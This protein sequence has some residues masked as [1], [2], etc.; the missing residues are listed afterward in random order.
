MN[1]F[2][3]SSLVLD[4]FSAVEEQNIQNDTQRAVDALKDQVS[5]Q[6]NALRDWSGWDN[7]YAFMEDRNDE[8]VRSSLLLNSNFLNLQVNL[9]I[10]AD[11]S[12]QIV[13]SKAY[14]LN[15][16]KS[17]D[18]GTAVTAL[19]SD[20]KLTQ[21]NTPG[22]EMLPEGAIIV[23]S[24][25]ILPADRNGIIR[26]S[27]IWGRYL[28]QA[29]IDKL[30]KLTHLT[31]DVKKLSDEQLPDDFRDA[32]DSL[33]NAPSVVKP[34]DNDN[35]AGYS[36]IDDIHGN[37][38]LILRVSG[39]RTIFSQAQVTRR[40]LV[41]AIFAAGLAFGGGILLLLER[42]VL[43]R[44]ARLS[45]GLAKITSTGN[46]ASR[47]Q[48]DGSDEL[49]NLASDINGM[50]AALEHS[51]R[52]VR[53]A[54]DLLE[55]KVQDRTAQLREKIAVLQTLTEIDREV[56]GAT[57]SKN[58]LTL[59]CHR[60][61]ELL[62][63]PKGL[64]TLSQNG[65][66]KVA[67]RVGL[68]DAEAVND[69]VTKLLLTEKTE[70]NSAQETRAITNIA[71][72]AAAGGVMKVREDIKS[73]AIAP[74]ATESRDL[75]SLMVFDTKAR[76][77]KADELQVLHLLAVQAALALEEAQLLE[78]EQSRREELGSLY[79]LSRVL[80]DSPPVIDIVVER[81]A[82]HA[83]LTTHV[84]FAAV[85]L[86]DKKGECVLRAS[87]PV[88]KLDPQPARA[89]SSAQRN[90]FCQKIMRQDEP[91]VINRE[92]VPFCELVRQQLLPFPAHT[93]CI[94]PLRAGDRSIGFI[95]LGE[96]RHPEREP[97]SQEKLRL[98][99]SIADQAVS[100]LGR[101]ELFNQLEQS[102]METVLSLAGAV[103]AR[104]A[105]TA[106]HTES[107]V[108]MALAIAQELNFSEQELDDLR[109]GVMLHDVGKIGIP[110]SVLQKPSKLT[111]A[112]WHKM[113]QHPAIGARIMA[114]VPRFKSAALVVRHHHERF[115]GHGYPDG[116]NGEAI[117][118]GARILCVV[119]S[120]SA[121]V[122][123]RV[124]KESFSHEVAS[125]GLKRCANSQFDAGIVDIFLRLCQ[126]G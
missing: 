53:A 107:L 69:E 108:E 9:M 93:V 51:Q 54:R 99:R 80:A 74:L 65:S 27:L 111:E 13:L 48:I 85:A 89:I 122:D 100:A 117:P 8:F 86:F 91:V 98:V 5:S 52:Q 113:K 57:G 60:A 118:L 35:I 44:T 92:S 34:L 110:D 20:K 76:S 37:P 82:K 22:I 83:A 78:D 3:L 101:A 64:I 56:T 23:A 116:L 123:K 12:G 39:P 95:M 47:V 4:G 126:T 55:V 87:Y 112:E 2:A 70:D 36:T 68:R 114:S 106:D 97:F 1:Y 120:Y 50:L 104:D 119:D 19:A 102:Y 79:G 42:S 90:D 61:A 45:S 38:A 115:D 15:Q 17:V 30:E 88:R 26:G 109:F 49:S 7:T 72:M 124:Y 81:V 10:L 43:S 77:W 18:T 71:E 66:Q 32:R 58:I 25:P 24:Q 59:V 73:L 29:Q 21:S 41:Y 94:V 62:Q 11:S 40:Y 6:N 96:E 31:L 33:A 75:G 125:A 105:Y 63:A 46:H 121:M 67:A 28:D 16:K 103:E 84:T 14:D